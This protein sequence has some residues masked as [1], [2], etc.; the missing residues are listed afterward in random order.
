MR[1][2]STGFDRPLHW[3]WP[4]HAYSEDSVCFRVLRGSYVDGRPI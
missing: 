3:G 1:K 2:K 4:K